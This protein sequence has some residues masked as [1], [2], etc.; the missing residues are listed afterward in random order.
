MKDG[1][2]LEKENKFIEEKQ[3]E[4]NKI[5]TIFKLNKESL[6]ID[7]YNNLELFNKIKDLA[8]SKGGF[9]NNNN[10]KK[11]WD[12]I[13]YKRKNKKGI[14]DIIKINKN[15]ELYIT[16]LNLISA[17]KELTEEK[18]NNINEYKVILNDLP[19]TCKT[20]VTND[21]LNLLNSYNIINTNSQINDINT[22]SQISNINTNS[23]ISNIFNS[24]NKSSTISSKSY[25]SPEIF[26]FSCDKLNYKYLQ[27]LLNIVF[28]FTKIF[29]YENCIN[30]L[31]IYFEYFFKDF[32]D[33]ELN[34]KNNDENIGLISS[35]ISELYNY[36]Y[37]NVKSDIIEEYIPILC[38]KWV[39]SNFVSEVKDINKGFR[40]LD[41]LIVNEPYIKYI[42]TTVLMHKINSRILDKMRVSSLDSSFDDL[43]SEIRKD[44]L[45]PIDFDEIIN[46]VENINDKSGK[47]IKKLLN[48]K[49]GKNYIYSFHENNQGLISY[50]KNLVKNLEIPKP[51]R[52][53]KIKINIGNI[54]IYK[55][56]FIVIAI[57]FAIYC[58]YNYIDKSRFFW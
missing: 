23:Q 50:Y 35:I 29:K 27:G 44:D 17:N 5:I 13:F 20:I 4:I 39:I 3:I 36:L 16:K 41:Y 43:F 56:L 33:K 34:E 57:S 24:I 58:I 45:N 52:E 42:M 9:L 37:S 15:I 28:Y 48:E 2:V 6:L 11:L 14:I 30:A 19:R 47:A 51:K 31:N 54:K 46:E 7:Q 12:Y 26:M 49:Y 40:I 1:I 18:L 8:K 22:N 10:R 25:I 32:I 38:N 55:Y 21:S 53:F